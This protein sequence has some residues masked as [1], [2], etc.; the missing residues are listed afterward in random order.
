MI[1]WFGMTLY[2]FLYNMIIEDD[3]ELDP[4]IKVIR[5]VSYVDIKTVEDEKCS[6]SSFFVQ[7]RKLKIK[8]FI[9][10]YEMH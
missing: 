5:E 1:L 4:L 10:H 8:K 9:V 3:H 6:I 7:F 2:K